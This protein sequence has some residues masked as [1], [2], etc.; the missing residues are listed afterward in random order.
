MRERPGDLASFPDTLLFERVA[1]GVALVVD[2]ALEFAGT[3]A[4]ENGRSY[5]TGVLD[6][7]AR[8]GRCTREGRTAERWGRQ[9]R[10]G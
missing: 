3:F 4:G 5:V 9:A 2:E 1:E 7:L 8:A 10:G 6:R